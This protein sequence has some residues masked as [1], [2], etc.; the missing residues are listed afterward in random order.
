[1]AKASKND[2]LELRADALSRHESAKK[3]GITTNSLNSYWLP[4]WGINS[5]EAEEVAIARYKESIKAKAED[6]QKPT[7]PVEEV[8]AE[9]LP[10][11]QPDDE[12]YKPVLNKAEDEA[13]KWLLED[14][15]KEALL[16]QHAA[17]PNGWQRGTQAEAMNGMSVW[18]LAQALITGYEVE[19][20]MEEKLLAAYKAALPYQAPP[21]VQSAFREGMKKA[22]KITGIKVKWSRN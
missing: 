13:I 11:T 21:D 20:T 14:W 16:Q 19:L 4:K 12:P 7:V 8:A 9:T 1:M 22:C 3:L 15:S 10:A 17:T 6:N 5:T 18:L 2:Y